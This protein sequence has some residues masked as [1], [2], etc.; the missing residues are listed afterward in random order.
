MWNETLDLILKG[1]SMVTSSL[2]FDGGKGKLPERIKHQ[3]HN[4][5]EPAPMAER[6]NA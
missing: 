4:D 5:P 3:F 1:P 6:S 2:Y